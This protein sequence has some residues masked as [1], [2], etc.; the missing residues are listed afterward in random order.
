M[1]SLV[2][3]SLPRDILIQLPN[4]L[5][6]IEDL[7]NVSSTCRSLY[8]CMGAA[9]PNVILRLAAA[10]TNVFFRPSPYF[11]VAAT[12]RE[13]GNWARR[14]EANEQELAVAM[15]EGADGL[16]DL[17]LVQCGLTLERIRQLHLM[18]FSIINPVADLIDKCVGAQWYSTPNFWSGGVSD[19]NTIDSDP[20]VSFFHLAIYGELF[21]PDFEIFLNRDSSSQVLSVDTRLEFIKYCVPEVMNLRAWLRGLDDSMAVEPRLRVRLTGPYKEDK[22]GNFKDNNNNNTALS[23]VIQSSRWI[24]HWD[25]VRS[26]AGPDFEDAFHD[27]WRWSRH[28]RY[29][30]WRQRLWENTIACQG[31]EGLGMIRPKLQDQ[32]IPKIREW[33]Q[34]IANLENEPPVVRVGGNTTFEYPYLLGDLSICKGIGRDSI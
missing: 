25:E 19:A 10:Q 15:Q 4:Y 26:K 21:A 17:A 13:L 6:T 11:L 28:D 29:R 3:L 7:M 14:S 16:L 32:W 22:V 27:D 23:W 2:L 5:H 18:R 24:P 33:R 12:A 30:N 20:P 31:L 34:R 9:T 1:D 8:S